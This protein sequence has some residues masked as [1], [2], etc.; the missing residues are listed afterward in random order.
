M[1]GDGT[2]FRYRLHVDRAQGNVWINVKSVC[3]HHGSIVRMLVHIFDCQLV[4]VYKPSCK[5]RVI[6]FELVGHSI[7]AAKSPCVGG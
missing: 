2:A 7:D 3:K 5:F 4:G 1:P 6:V